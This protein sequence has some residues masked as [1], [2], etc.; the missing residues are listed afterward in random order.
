MP[1]TEY[2]TSTLAPGWTTVN[3]IFG[4][5]WIFETF[6]PVVNHPLNT[7]KIYGRR[8]GNCGNLTVSIKLADGDH[9]PT[10]ADLVS[11]V[12][13]EADLPTTNGWITITL[14]K[15]TVSTGQEYAIVIRALDGNGT[16]YYAWIG[17]FII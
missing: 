7:V 2:E 9:K 4:D 8:V 10:G 12:V 11:T 1:A 5:T 15:I 6:T 17:N 13:L 14:N 16:K 3:K